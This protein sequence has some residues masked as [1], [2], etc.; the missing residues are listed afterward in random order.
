MGQSK[1]DPSRSERVTRRQ[2]V[3]KNA[4]NL[5]DYRS[6]TAEKP[7][8]VNIQGIGLCVRDPYYTRLTRQGSKNNPLS[9]QGNV[10]YRKRALDYATLE[11]AFRKKN[12]L[13]MF[14][15]YP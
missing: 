7:V 15:V 14:P 9:W 4:P 13:K 12:L 11:R 5:K 8:I 2:R 1:G 6:D 3:C 10:D